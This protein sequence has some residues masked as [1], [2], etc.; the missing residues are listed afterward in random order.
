MTEQKFTDDDK[1]T[2]AQMHSKGTN[3]RYARS[4]VW[5]NKVKRLGAQHDTVIA[6]HKEMEAAAKVNEKYM[7]EVKEVRTKA[8]RAQLNAELSA[9]DAA[10]LQIA[11]PQPAQGQAPAVDETPAP[12]P[13]PAP[14]APIADETPADDE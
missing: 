12:A 3:L 7:E 8:K 1:L 14:E 11:I 4:I 2:I 10:P 5:Y 9:L 6:A 13:A